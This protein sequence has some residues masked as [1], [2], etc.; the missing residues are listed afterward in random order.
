M[1][2]NIAFANA[3]F[4]RRQ[5][6][7]D[8]YVVD[9]HPIQARIEISRHGAV[10]KIHDHLARGRRLDVAR[11]NRRARIDNDNG[12][13]LA[14]QFERD[15]FRLP[16]RALVMI[17]HLRLRSETG[18]VGGNKPVMDRFGQPDAA[19]RAGINNSFAPRCGRRFEHVARPLHIGRVH[20]A[21]VPQPQ[22]V[23]GRHMKAP[24]A[25]AHGL[26]QPLAVAH[27]PL[28]RLESRAGQTSQIGSRPQQRLYSMAAYDQFMHQVRA[29]KS[30]SAG[31]EAV[32][33][34]P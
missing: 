12:Q 9:V 11:A 28:D 8:G 30:R 20:R 14:R 32:H 29:N 22:M 5:D 1:A 2:Q 24:I 23:T 25:P 31:D 3:A 18:F 4:L 16:L 10:E 34:L 17:A 33:A 6:M 13:T 19:D 27:V 26:L 15:L 21:V 7:A